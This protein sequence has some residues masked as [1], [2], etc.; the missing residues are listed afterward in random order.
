ML[1]RAALALLV[2]L[3]AVT[4]AG[5]A[6]ADVPPAMSPRTIALP[7]GPGSM[8]GLGESF[9]PNLSSG[10]GNFSV[11]LDLPP[12]LGKPGLSLQYTH[13]RGRTEVG[14]SFS[15]PRLAIYR[16]RDKGSPEFKETDRFAVSGP[17]FTDELVEVNAEARY[18]RLKNEGAFALF[19]RDAQ[20][21]AWTIRYP[22]GDT[23]ELGTDGGARQWSVRGSYK[24]FLTT[25]TDVSGNATA[26]TYFT[27][28]GYVY[29]D[30]I[31]YRLRAPDY[32]NE[33]KLTYER[34]E[35]PFT[36][37]GYGSAV[38][39]GQ[40]LSRIEM[41][42][43][44]GPGCVRT[45][46]TYVLGYTK[47]TQSYLSSV[48]QTG[49][50]GTPDVTMPTLSFTY[51]EP[52]PALG[53]TVSMRGS[54]PL[55]LVDLG[56]AQ[57]DD[58]TGDGL[59]DVV[60]GAAFNYSYY[61]NQG[62]WSW[63]D[64]TPLSRSPDVSL[65]DSGS[66]VVLV[67]VNG[68]G[69]RD[70]LRSMGSEYLYF[71]GGNVAGGKF[72]GYRPGVHVAAPPSAPQWSGASNR[73]ADLNFDGR[74]DILRADGAHSVK[75][76]SLAD[77]LGER[78]LE[79]ADADL[80]V[81]VARL[82]ASPTL[83]MHDFNGDG[84][85]D[86][87]IN[88]TSWGDSRLR[89]FY[90]LGGGKFTPSVS[91]A[92]P[93][94]NRGDFLLGDINNDGYL[95][96]V[97]YTGQQITYWLG[98]GDERLM[99]PFG[100][101]AA[102]SAPS[103]SEA[104]SVQLI[105]MDGSGTS[106]LVILTRTGQIV[107]VSLF[108]NPFLGLLT[109]IDNGMG[110]VS[111]IGYRT[112]SQYATDAKMAGAPWRTTLPRPIAVVSEM[113]VTDSL[114]KIGLP[115][116]VKTTKYDYAD[117]YY[118]GRERE[119]RGFGF[120]RVTDPGDVHDETRVSETWMH[121]G[122]NPDSGADE[123]ILKGKPYR[124]VV[125]NAAGEIYAS[126]ETRWSTRWLCAEDGPEVEPFLPKCSLYPNRNEAKDS[127]VALATQDWLLKGAWEKT[128]APRYTLETRVYDGWGQVTEKGS[129]GEVALPA[130][131]ALGEPFDVKEVK[132]T[133]PGDEVITTSLFA[134]N[135]K[136][137]LIGVPYASETHDLGLTPLAAHR[138]Y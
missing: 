119:F 123:E 37:Y 78:V 58:V 110:M 48:T 115:A 72:L 109:Q 126:E 100:P 33:V 122:V 133:V 26:Y 112:S 42:S 82:F 55:D 8:K 6:R 54:V 17:G 111:T 97:R 7:S 89:V 35:D 15:L 62:G 21:D 127:L 95:D 51:V 132:R 38:T 68:D 87:V 114:D 67:D 3:V 13:G 92:A 60:V 136:V 39:C 34:R 98:A 75:D 16:T 50:G 57:F 23:A 137:W 131:R 105:D 64:A 9:S 118:D 61:E 96:L 116:T 73:L 12:G 52:S 59:P 113:T 46:R 41:R 49:E 124:M 85:Q 93:K 40:R 91:I 65:D 53:T 107:Y 106:D 1:Q 117:G 76:L 130:T 10:A 27:D 22:N 83:Q 70:V 4:V 101:N 103:R 11:P 29:L 47:T 30:K 99:G 43:G 129:Y 104:R 14:A 138:T 77:G 45:V 134:S 25:L 81:D 28:R 32:E 94:G 36:D 84:A 20:R 135:T 24:W 69:F 121:L 88:E 125:K 74:T 66:G 108:S 79:S 128:G 56:R 71:P 90:G 80:P 31:R 19:I 44:C 102:W 5:R 86:F 120:V 63:A 18:Y 2:V